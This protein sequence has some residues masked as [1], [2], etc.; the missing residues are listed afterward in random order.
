MD[1]V[2]ELMKERLQKWFSI[3]INEG[4]DKTCSLK[5]AIEKNIT[6]GMS[7]HI[8]TTHGRPY[9]LI[10]ELI[11]RF[12]GKF[13]KFEIITIGLT[14]PMAAIVH[15]NLARRCVTTFVGDSYPTPGPNLV[16]QKAYKEGTVQ[17]QQWSILTMPLRLKAA[18][19]N[20]AGL[21][22][23]SLL[24]STME[25]ENAED[26]R[27]IPDPFQPD[28]SMGF[29]KPLYPDIAFLHGWVADRNGNALFTPPYGE[30][31]Y[32]AMASR[33]GLVLSVEKIVS[34][35]FIRRH[36]NLIK[37][38]GY[39]VK[40]VTEVPMGSH[41]SGL[42]KQGIS[43]MDAYAD[44]YKFLEV[45][46]NACRKPETFD[47]WIKTWILEPGSQEEY[48]SRVGR[49]RIGYLKGKAG[50]DSWFADILEFGS[51]VDWNE[52]ASS[53]E[54]MILA[55]AKL[56]VERVEKNEYRNI[57][58][59]VG[60]ANLA[61]W[62][63]LKMLHDKEYDVEMMAEIGF[64]GFSPRP[65]D[66]FIFNYRNMPTC[67]MLTDIETIMGHFVSGSNN[68]NLGAIGAGQ[69]DRWGN[70]NSTVIPGHTLLVGSGGAND[71]ASGSNE[72]LVIVMQERLR[73]PEK[74]PY[75]TSPGGNVQT[76]VSD[77]GV[78][79]KLPGEKELT[80]TRTLSLS[81]NDSITTQVQ[82]IKENC[83]WDLKIKSPV[84]KLDVSDR[85]ILEILRY[86]DPKGLFLGKIKA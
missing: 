50:K 1:N 10:Y 9:G 15:G 74:V 29:L 42:S 77:K 22:T 47:K 45:T 13:P 39:L 67:K 73:F 68:K 54:S 33:E 83:G 8:G 30:G 84:K 64:Y 7:I 12:W 61:S 82:E 57:L 31:F 46:R 6:H 40:S 35:D 38:P 52:P 32:G 3:P 56:M 17:F 85:D 2:S 79:E 14:G 62:L 21:P 60:A 18:A 34:T 43:E 4:H 72:T 53:I 27:V 78:F 80:L 48:L 70:V 49:D 28:R 58:A 19:M 51:N 20:V 86:F 81:N 36:N 41:P 71:I 63:A 26:F 65:A 25:V 24:G 37:V 59:G 75:I 76:V 23:K 44:D 66:P 16:Y 11:R 69:V 5:E 55:A